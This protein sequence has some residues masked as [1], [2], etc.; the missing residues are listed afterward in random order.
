M[1]LRQA[2]QLRM[3]A[4]H[5]AYKRGERAGRGKNENRRRQFIP[6]PQ[7]GDTGSVRLA[8]TCGTRFI[9]LVCW[10]PFGIH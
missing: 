8:P 2:I 10:L 7:E 1:R 3:L 9:Q 4:K 5:R 6:M